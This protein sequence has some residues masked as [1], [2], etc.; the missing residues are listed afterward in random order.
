MDADTIEEISERIRAM[1]L[2][3][4]TGNFNEEFISRIEA[5]IGLY[6]S[7]LDFNNSSLK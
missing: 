6:E 3:L 4:D 5:R 7:E 1:R 2:L